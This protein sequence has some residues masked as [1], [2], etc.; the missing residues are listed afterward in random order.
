MKGVITRQVT[1]KEPEVF[2]QLIRLFSEVFEMDSTS[3]TDQKHLTSLLNKEEFIVLVAVKSDQVIGGLTGFVLP[4][5][6]TQKS[7]V[8]LY[9][10]AVAKTYQR[11]GIGK[12]LLN[13]LQDICI[14]K[15]YELCYVQ[16]DQT[17]EQAVNFYRKNQPSAE[18]DVIHFTYQTG[19]NP[20]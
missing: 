4:Q 8:Y 16:A 12:S 5:Y 6:Y 3:V 2:E 11:N 13:A 10:L 20:G 9:D 14:T 7:Q 17:E 15:G 19:P 1:A 18:L